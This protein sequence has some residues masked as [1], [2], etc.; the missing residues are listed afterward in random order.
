MAEFFRISHVSPLKLAVIS[1]ILNI[2]GRSLR[3]LRLLLFHYSVLALPDQ[4]RQGAGKPSAVNQPLV[5]SSDLAQFQFSH[6]TSLINAFNETRSFE[7][8]NFDG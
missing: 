8:V 1:D 3:S 6:Q 2:P 5:N 4:T 7:S